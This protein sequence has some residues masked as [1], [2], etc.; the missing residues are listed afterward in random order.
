MD[1][2]RSFVKVLPRPFSQF[3]QQGGQLQ[4]GIDGELANVRTTHGAR[5]SKTP[6]RPVLGDGVTA[7]VGVAEDEGV[8]A[9]GAPGLED[10]KA[11]AM[12]RVE[13]MGD[14]RPPQT[15][16]VGLCS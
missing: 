14:R 1:D 13:W 8:D 7:A 6:I 5:I 11:L 2:K 4:E 3:A 12:Q 10:L 16:V 15:G 9:R